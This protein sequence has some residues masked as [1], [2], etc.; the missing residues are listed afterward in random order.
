M[1]FQVT[2]VF[3]PSCIKL[4]LVSNILEAKIEVPIHLQVSL[5]HYS[6]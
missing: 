1:H 4:I 5:S 3:K 2:I 6:Y